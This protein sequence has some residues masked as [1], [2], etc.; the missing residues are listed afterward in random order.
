MPEDP[1]GELQV[2]KEVLDAVAATEKIG[3]EDLTKITDTE[4]ITKIEIKK[5][6]DRDILYNQPQTLYSRTA[7]E[8]LKEYKPNYPLG[9][10]KETDM[11]SE[12][13]QLVVDFQEQIKTNVDKQVEEMIEDPIPT[14]TRQAD[15]LVNTVQ[16][17]LTQL[18]YASTYTKYIMRQYR[19]DPSVF[20]R[21][22][23]ELSC[24]PVN[25]G[26]AHF[27]CSTPPSTPNSSVTSGN[28]TTVHT[29]T[30]QG[31][32]GAGCQSWTAKGKL[33]IF[34]DMTQSAARVAAAAEAYGNPYDNVNS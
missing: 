7:V 10:L 9:H 17:S 13:Q 26:C 19:P 12:M 29:Y 8:G 20:T 24:K 3:D 11:S 5:D 22:N 21:I 34:N 32:F 27:S 14:I 15:V 1:S 16:G 6:P 23:V 28:T 31:M 30:M 33:K 25:E 4:F 18:P 2:T